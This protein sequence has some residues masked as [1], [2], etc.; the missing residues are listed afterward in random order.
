MRI[1]LDECTPRRL[2]LLLSGHEVTTVSR[3]GWNGIK[4]GE[5]LRRITAAGH[6]VFITVDQSLEYEQ[7]LREHGSLIVCVL[8]GASNRESDLAPLMR[9]AAVALETA[10]PGDLIRIG[11]KD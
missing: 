3:A 11:K 6:E 10:V 7:N 9:Q 2:R 8:A 1:I 4:N 5:L